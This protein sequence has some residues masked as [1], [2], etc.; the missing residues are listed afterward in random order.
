MFHPFSETAWEFLT[1]RLERSR[2]SYAVEYIFSREA[3]DAAGGFVDFPLGWCSD[4]ASWARFAG[5]TPIQTIAGPKVS[6]RLSGVNLSSRGTPSQQEKKVDALFEFVEWP[7]RQ[8][9]TQSALGNPPSASTLDDLCQ[10]W[11]S[12]HLLNDCQPM[13]YPQM[14][15]VYRRVRRHWPNERW[16]AWRILM[17]SLLLRAPYGRRI[18]RAPLALRNRIRRMIKMMRS[19]GIP[20]LE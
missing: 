17:H 2:N 1:A 13:A 5:S 3:F 9:A 14:L 11:I 8:A 7:R 16:R 18:R 19:E 6:W 4:D 10:K 20:S 15:S 12:S